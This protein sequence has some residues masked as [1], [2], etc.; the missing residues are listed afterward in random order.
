MELHAMRAIERI[1]SSLVFIR[2]KLIKVFFCLSFTKS[3]ETV[4]K[5][6]QKLRSL[7][8]STNFASD[9]PICAYPGS[10][11][12][13]FIQALSPISYIVQYLIL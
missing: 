11:A 10:N 9:L 8:E 7:S 13:V 4:V 6:E 1:K 2:F 12:I 5:V 3:W